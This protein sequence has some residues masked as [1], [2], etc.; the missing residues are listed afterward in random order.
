MLDAGV[1]TCTAAEEGAEANEAEEVDEVDE[2]VLRCVLLERRLW[3]SLA[4]L[5]VLAL[6]DM[7]L[8]TRF[9]ELA[10]PLF[11]VWG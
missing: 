5:S 10:S 3:S 11:G 7:V 4:T 6:P 8:L 2:L 9:M 1:P